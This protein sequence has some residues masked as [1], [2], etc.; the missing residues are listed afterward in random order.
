MRASLS[1]L[2]HQDLS[3]S[4]AF[5]SQVPSLL[6]CL[7]FVWFEMWFNYRSTYAS[8]CRQL[9]W[10]LMIRKGSTNQC[11]QVLSP[12]CAA[13]DQHH[14][15][16]LAVGDSLGQLLQCHMRECGWHCLS[17]VSYGY[18][19]H[20]QSFNACRYWR[21]LSVGVNSIPQTWTTFSIVPSASLSFSAGCWYPWDLAWSWIC[22]FFCFFTHPKGVLHVDGKRRV[23]SKLPR[24]RWMALAGRNGS[25]EAPHP[26]N[27]FFA[28]WKSPYA[29]TG[30]AKLFRT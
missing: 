14:Q 1:S 29:A 7:G 25:E 17:R 21:S 11:A 23:S 28:V 27:C 22:S 6:L 9:R 16:F 2:V 3:W 24:L 5:R 18:Q 15:M 20:R 8:L 19:T 30:I 13:L 10:I 26:K 12:L 4:W